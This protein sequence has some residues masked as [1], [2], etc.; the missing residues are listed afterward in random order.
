MRSVCFYCEKDGEKLFW[1]GRGLASEGV[2]ILIFVT[3]AFYFSCM[4]QLYALYSAK[5]KGSTDGDPDDD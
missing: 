4:V 5:C 3:M 2:L 1:E